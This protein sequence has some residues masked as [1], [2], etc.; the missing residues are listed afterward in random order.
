MLTSLI[1]DHL[2]FYPNS[3]I[4]PFTWI[5]I[6]TSFLSLLVGFLIVLTIF[7]KNKKNK[8][9][10]TSSV[11]DHHMKVEG[12]RD[13]GLD[14]TKAEDL[15]RLK[16]EFISIV[17][18]ELRTP[19]TSIYATLGLLNAD[20][21]L[22]GKSKEL[23]E[24]AYRNTKRL[25]VIINDILDLDN[26][27]L[28]KFD[29]KNEPVVLEQVIRETLRLYQHFEEEYKVAFVEENM[30]MNVKVNA[31]PQKLHQVIANILSNAAKFS[32]ING[33]IYISMENLGDQVRVLIRDEGEGIPEDYHNKIFTRFYRIDV[34]DARRTKGAGL[35]LIICKKIIKQLG[36]EVGFTSK[37]KQGSTFYFDLP[38]IK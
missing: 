19:L 7:Y 18:H 34:S 1:A 17:S 8:D 26:L 38:Q 31:D 30:L 12:L 2:F 37:P 6:Y 29:I 22:K 9:Q 27:D 33:K 20:K 10:N 24:V 32:K 3:P 25:N 4:H 5:I 15:E 16:S 14:V 35:G 13:N 28:G 36:G 21:D 11:Y 23:V